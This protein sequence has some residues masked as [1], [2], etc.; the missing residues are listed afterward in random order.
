MGLLL[1]NIPILLKFLGPAYIGVPQLLLILGFSKLIDLGTGLNSQILQ[2]SKH[3]KI[4]LFTNMLFVVLSIILN[5][6][7]TKKY[8]IIGTAY[9]GLIAIIGFN[10]MR[11]IYI[12]KIYNLQPFTPSNLLTL[13][14]AATLLFSIHTIPTISNTWATAVIK[15]TLF[16]SAFS[17]F[18]IR[19][20]ISDDLTGLFHLALE[21]L[22]ITKKEEQ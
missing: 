18:I 5:Y 10:L 14:V 22:R 16:V 20:K 12:K 17:F 8:G 1:I 9:G 13:V 2:L 6:I 3:W 7:L 19:F 4:D 15:S 21:K 11:F